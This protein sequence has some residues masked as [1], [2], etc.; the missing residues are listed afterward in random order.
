MP[1]YLIDM[2]GVIYRGA[3]LIEGAKPFID[4]LVSLRVP[5]LFLTNNSQRS[6]RDVVLRLKRLGIH[7][8]EEHIFTCAMATARFLARQKPE[9]SA[10]VIGE[11]GLIPIT[12]SSAKDE[13]SILK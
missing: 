10:Y 7:V 5:F 2:D 12:L 9:G 8:E 3:E 1:G 4:E 13:P 6:R 11:G